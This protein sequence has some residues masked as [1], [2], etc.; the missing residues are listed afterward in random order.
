MMLSMP[1]ACM[2]HRSHQVQ[3]MSSASTV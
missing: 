2:Q 3:A 1:S